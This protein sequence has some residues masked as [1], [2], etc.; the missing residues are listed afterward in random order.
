[1][2]S[3]RCYFMDKGRIIGV[4]VLNTTRD[5]EAIELCKRAHQLRGGNSDGYE[6]WQGSRFVHRC[7]PDYAGGPQ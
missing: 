5:D 2:N 3:Y 7:G 6:V 4:E 1:M